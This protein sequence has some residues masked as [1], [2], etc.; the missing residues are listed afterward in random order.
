MLFRNL[1]RRDD[2]H[3]R[4]YRSD[5]GN[6]SYRRESHPVFSRLGGR[7][8]WRGASSLGTISKCR[9]RRLTSSSF[10]IATNAESSHPCHVTWPRPGLEMVGRAPRDAHT[11]EQR[12]KI[13]SRPCPPTPCGW[14][15]SLRGPPTKSAKRTPDDIKLTMEL[16]RIVGKYQQSVSPVRMLSIPVGRRACASGQRHHHAGVC[17]AVGAEEHRGGQQRGSTRIR[18][19]VLDALIARA[20][21]FWALNLCA[22]GACVEPP[23]LASVSGRTARS[24]ARCPLAP[25][26]P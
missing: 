26:P 7:I 16:K 12:R 21:F 18:D 11:V 17:H 2:P 15:R 1:L 4:P 22:H 23:E 8:V 24:P 6:V 10:A 9:R 5:Q 19:G 25:Q 20:P 3:D 13:N 14:R